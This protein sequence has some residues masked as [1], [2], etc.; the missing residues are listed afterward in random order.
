VTANAAAV[1]PSNATTSRVE[2][3]RGTDPRVYLVLSGRQTGS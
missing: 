3:K 1:P 2:R